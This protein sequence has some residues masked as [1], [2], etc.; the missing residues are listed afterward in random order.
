MKSLKGCRSGFVTGFI[1]FDE[2]NLTAKPALF[3]SKLKGLA[4][5]VNDP[6]AVLELL[7]TVP[8]REV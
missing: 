4:A 1:G 3:P 2:K 5:L 8:W 6:H 7:D